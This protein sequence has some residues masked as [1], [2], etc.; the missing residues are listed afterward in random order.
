MDT[1]LKSV[2]DLLMSTINDPKTHD[3]KTPTCVSDSTSLRVGGGGPGS[4]GVRSGSYSAKGGSP[5]V[6][7]RSSS[8]ADDP[9]NQATTERKEGSG[10]HLKV[11]IAPASAGQPAVVSKEGGDDGDEKVQVD[12]KHNDGAIDLKT[13]MVKL[14]K[15]INWTHPIAKKM[16]PR[17]HDATSKYKLSD[18]EMENFE[19]FSTAVNTCDN[20]EDIVFL[21]KS[22]SS[23]IDVLKK[24]GLN[25]KKS[26]I[27]PYVLNLNFWT[28]R[29]R[30]FKIRLSMLVMMSPVGIWMAKT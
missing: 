29:I 6:N 4:T 24:Q 1:E 8:I 18:G 30:D 10:M 17:L 27:V 7:L 3:S 16:I 9:T 11:C 12:V 20:N 2:F 23:L 19:E 15:D 25:G 13:T 14:F 22:F 5:R 21:V 26:Q 28:P